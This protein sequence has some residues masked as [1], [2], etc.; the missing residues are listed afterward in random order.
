MATFNLV[1][2]SAAVSADTAVISDLRNGLSTVT[3]YGFFGIN[4]GKAGVTITKA[5]TL[6]GA[7]LP[8]TMPLSLKDAQDLTVE[9]TRL[10]TP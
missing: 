5:A 7:Q 8:L 3:D 1:S 10:L 2:S 6:K 9:L 4:V